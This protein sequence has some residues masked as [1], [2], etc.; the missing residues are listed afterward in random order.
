M[1][2]SNQMYNITLLSK[3]LKFI[4]FVEFILNL[5]LSIGLTLDIFAKFRPGAHEIEHFTYFA[6]THSAT[7]VSFIAIVEYDF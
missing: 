4:D 2:N 3:L 5:L 6:Q 1:A 7:P